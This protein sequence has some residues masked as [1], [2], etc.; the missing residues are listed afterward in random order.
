MIWGVMAQTQSGGPGVT[1]SFYEFFCGG[2]LA[3]AGLGPRWRCR[4][5]NDIDPKKAA[6]YV[7]KWGAHWFHLGDV[8]ALPPAEALDQGPEP[9]D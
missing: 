7:E 3:R 6:S 5:A 2:G 4:L 8:A 9:V 1:H